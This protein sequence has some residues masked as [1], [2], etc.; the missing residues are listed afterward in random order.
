[1]PFEDPS[2]FIN[3]ELSMLAFQ[4][5]VLEEA[6]DKANPPYERLKFL[7]IVASNLDEFFMVRVAGVKQQL[8]GGVLE[9]SADGKVPQEQLLAIAEQAQKLV[10]EQYRVY[11]EL[12]IDLAEKA[13]GK[14]LSNSE[15]AADQLA[16]AREYFASTVFPSLTP[17]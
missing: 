8:Q 6:E 14:V 7:S 9:K 1:M 12:L 10:A 4:R 15:L 5:R 3:R 2:L 13:G 16:P 17:L 11:R